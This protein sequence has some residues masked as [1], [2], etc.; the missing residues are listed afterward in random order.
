M[1]SLEEEKK[2]DH[3]RRVVPAFVFWNVWIAF[4]GA[5]ERFA[6]GLERE[7]IVLPHPCNDRLPTGRLE[8]SRVLAHLHREIDQ[9]RDDPDATDEVTQIAERFENAGSC[10]LAGSAIQLHPTALTPTRGTPAAR[11]VS[12]I[13]WN[14]LPGCQLQSLVGRGFSGHATRGDCWAGKLPYL[15]GLGRPNSEAKR[16]VASAMNPS[17]GVSSWSVRYFTNSSSRP[18]GTKLTSIVTASPEVFR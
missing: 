15:A 10:W 8:S 12:R 18:P 4:S 17:A 3:S 14:E 9:S 16:R 1:S 2:V 7:P 5:K 13:E 11:T 6:T